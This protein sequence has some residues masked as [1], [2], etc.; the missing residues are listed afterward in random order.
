MPGPIPANRPTGLLSPS[1]LHHISPPYPL[2]ASGAAGLPSPSPAAPRRKPHNTKEQQWLWEEKRGF[3]S[4]SLS[5][6]LLEKGRDAL[7]SGAFKKKKIQT[8]GWLLREEKARRC[9]RVWAPL[10]VSGILLPL[11]INS[12]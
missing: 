11:Q 6:S 9:N 3:F 2:R 5:V 7:Q 1:P 12:V 8:L 10:S 4:L